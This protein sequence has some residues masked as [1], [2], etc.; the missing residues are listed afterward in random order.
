MLSSWPRLPMP[1]PAQRAHAGASSQNVGRWLQSSCEQTGRGGVHR[2]DCRYI[3][4]GRHRKRDDKSQWHATRNPLTMNCAMR[5]H[6]QR[7]YT[8]IQRHIKRTYTET[9]HK[10]LHNENIY[11]CSRTILK[12]YTSE[13]PAALNKM[14]RTTCGSLDCCFSKVQNCSEAFHT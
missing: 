5:V 11:T 8:H 7:T 13:A 4:C 1:T 6:I 2:W 12:K 14:H 3:A 9:R 10:S